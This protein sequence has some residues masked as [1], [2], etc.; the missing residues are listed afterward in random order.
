MLVELIRNDTEKNSGLH[1]YLFNMMAVMAF[2]AERRGRLILQGELDEYTRWLATAITV[3]V[4]IPARVCPL[5]W[6][7]VAWL[8]TGSW[9]T[10]ARKNNR[11][12][13]HCWSGVFSG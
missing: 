8:P 12:P 1:S 9:M 7:Q 6:S 3:P 13:D 10:C 5:P 4:P 2:D 11:K